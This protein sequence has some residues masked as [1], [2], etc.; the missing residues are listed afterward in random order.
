MA[1]RLELE[2]RFNDHASAGVKRLGKALGDVKP[3]NGM[4]AASKWMAEFRG[5]ADKAFKPAQQVQGA[6]TGIGIGGL[7]ASMSMGAIVKTFRDLADSTATMKELGRQSGM[8]TIEIQRL[9]FVAGQLHVDPAAVSGAI[10]TWSSKMVEFRRHTGQLYTEMMRQNGDVAAKIAS[11]DPAQGFRDTLDFLS[12]IPAAAMKAGASAA[13]AAQIQKRWADEA[14]VGDLVPALAK[15]PEGLRD[16]YAEATREVKPLT[17]E[18][19]AQAEAL[20]QSLNR[21]D[22]TWKNFKTEFGPTVIGGITGAVNELQDV[23]EKVDA[24]RDRYANHPEN[25]TKDATKNEESIGQHFMQHWRDVAAGKTPLL[26]NPFDSKSWPEPERRVVR[27]HQA[28][29]RRDAV[30]RHVADPAQ[31]P[32]GL[33]RC[34]PWRRI[35]HRRRRTFGLRQMEGALGL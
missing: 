1:D 32:A 17:K 33:H 35:W 30:W 13:D 15:G 6:L 16:A 12:R 10:D 14:G 5:A 8:A 21:L 23:L 7:A 29:G 4:A 34:D 2:A 9:Q 27:L 18:L 26:P 19:E 25:V 24:A 31:E 20:N 28:R 22:Q 3:T 11:E